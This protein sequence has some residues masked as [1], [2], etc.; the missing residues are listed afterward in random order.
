[1]I[2]F[3]LGNINSG[4]SSTSSINLSDV[5]YITETELNEPDFFPGFLS[6]ANGGKPVVLLVAT[7]I[8]TLEYYLKCFTYG[9]KGKTACTAHH[10]RECELTQIVLDD[11]RRVTHFARMKRNA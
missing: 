10:I 6:G 2:L 5:E 8:K 7:T 9:R 1:M 3:Y 4:L 11:L